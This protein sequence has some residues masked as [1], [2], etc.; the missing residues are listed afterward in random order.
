MKLNEDELIKIYLV[1]VECLS[2]RQLRSECPGRRKI[3]I[4]SFYAGT[5]FEGVQ[6][7]TRFLLVTHSAGLV[8]QCVSGGEAHENRMSVFR[9]KTLLL[10]AGA[11]TLAP[12]RL[13]VIL[14][15]S[16]VSHM[17]YV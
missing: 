14:C 12:V 11:G 8:V 9:P 10:R 3:K 1:M 13:S 4:V 15:R 7:R 2:I 6:S 5:R 17:T 16:R